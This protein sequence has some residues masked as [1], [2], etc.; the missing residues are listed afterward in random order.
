[1]T[2]DRP[3]SAQLTFEYP[4]PASAATVARS[5]RPELG[6]IDSDRASASVDRTADTVTVTVDAA[7]LTALR[8]GLT[9]WTTLIEVAEAVD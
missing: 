1:M 2:G 7:D 6:E 9:T 4:S 5:V 3:H 8:A